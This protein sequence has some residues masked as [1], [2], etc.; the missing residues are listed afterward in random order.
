MGI[1]VHE[2]VHDTAEFLFEVDCIKRDVEHGFEFMGDRGHVLSLEARV[3]IPWL[4]DVQDPLDPNRTLLDMVQL[5]LF[6]DTGEAIRNE[7]AFNARERQVL[8]GY[9]AGIRLNY[10]EW[11][12]LRFDAAWPL[13]DDTWPWKSPTRVTPMCG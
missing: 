9:G 4:D 13:T 10:P 7:V 8:T 11:G 6:I 1:L 12:S 5:A 2:I 3:K